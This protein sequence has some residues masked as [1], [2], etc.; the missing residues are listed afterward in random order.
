MMPSDL[1][2]DTP[3]RSLLDRLPII[4]LDELNATASLLTRTDRK[5]VVH[6]TATTAA[7]ATLGNRFRVLDIDGYRESGYRS[8]YFDTAEF[9]LYRAAAHGRPRRYK[10]RVRTYTTSGTTVLEVKARTGRG[11]TTKH[12]TPS[13]DETGSLSAEQRR[14]VADVLKHEG[15]RATEHD[16]LPAM[17]TTYLRSTLLDA[18]TG[19][20][21]TIDR[22]LRY[23]AP[24]DAEHHATEALVIETKSVSQPSALDRVLWAAGHR[25]VRISKYAVAMSRHHPQLP[26]NRWRRVIESHFPA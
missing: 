22:G 8:T 15:L 19:T 25:P 23:A 11:D 21:V 12:R 9:H 16:L 3:L 17:T 1:L 13:H 26:N 2:D 6:V 4:D 5:Y 10:V 14:F 20:R 24:G 7:L 18:S